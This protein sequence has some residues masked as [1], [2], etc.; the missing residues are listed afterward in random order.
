ML[1]AR[2]LMSSSTIESLDASEIIRHLGDYFL[3]DAPA[4]RVERVAGVFRDAFGSDACLPFDEL[5]SRLRLASFDESLI[6]D[7]GTVLF[8]IGTELPEHGC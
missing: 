8:F 5:V 2:E 6:A 1:T 4:E 3:Q 7:V